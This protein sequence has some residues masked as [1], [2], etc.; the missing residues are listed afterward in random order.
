MAIMAQTILA[1]SILA[2]AIVAQAIL[3]QASSGLCLFHWD[4]LDWDRWRGKPAGSRLGARRP[5]GERQQAWRT[6]EPPG[7]DQKR[8]SSVRYMVRIVIVGPTALVW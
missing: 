6:P 3:A 7:V 5:R 1:Q 2:Q 8:C 4:G